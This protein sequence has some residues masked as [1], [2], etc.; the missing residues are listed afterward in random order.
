MMKPIVPKISIIANDRDYVVVSKPSGMLS[1]IDQSLDENNVQ[2]ILQ[3]RNKKKLH[4]LTR[5][6]RP[7]AGILI[8]SKNKDFTAHYTRLQDKGLITK[9]YHAIVEGHWPEDSTT[10]E[11]YLYHDQKYKKARVLDKPIDG[12]N[13]TVLH[14]QC[15]KSLENY[16][17]LSILIERG[18]FHQIRAQLSHAGFPIKGDVKYGARRG[19]KD[20]SIHLNASKLSFTNQKGETLNYTVD[21]PSE[22]N[23]WAIASEKK[24]KDNG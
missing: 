21:L 8:L 6:D 5:L 10:L 9:E 17:V 19:N 24:K 7:V 12:Y 16:S 3:S 4:L 11:N 23:L 20:R 14:V 22:D 2:Q 18:R 15:L 1:Q 13:K